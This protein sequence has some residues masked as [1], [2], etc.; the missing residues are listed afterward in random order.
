MRILRQSVYHGPNVYSMTPAVC[1][2][3]DASPFEHRAPAELGPTFIDVLSRVLPG[4]APAP[5]AGDRT[6][7]LGDPVLGWPLAIARAAIGLQRLIGFQVGLA[8][9][10]PMGRGEVAAIFDLGHPNLGETIAGAATRIVHDIA[11]APNDGAE[12]AA[13]IVRRMRDRHA[14]DAP[15]VMMRSLIAAIERRGIPWRYAHPQRRVLQLGH[16]CKMQRTTGNVAGRTSWIAGEIARDKALATRLLDDA[17]LP[18]TEQRLVGSVREGLAKAEELGFPVVVKPNFTGRGIAVAPMLQTAAQVEVALVAALEHGP[19]LVERHVEGDDHRLFVV[20]GR[21]VAVARKI[22]ASIVGDGVHSVRDLVDAVNRD[23]LRGATTAAALAEIVIDDEARRVL[24]GQGL[25]ETSVPAAGD[26]VLLRLNANLSTGGM[27]VDVTGKVHPDNIAMA[28][29]EARVIGLDIMGL[30]FLTPDI[31]RSHREV[32]GAICEVN[33]TPGVRLHAD[34]DLPTVVIDAIVD[35]MF[36]A[37]DDGR[38][39]IATITGSDGKTTTSHMVAAILQAAGHR[40]GLATTV[41]VRIDGVPVETGDRAGGTGAR[42]VLGDPSVTAAVLE[43]AH[44]GLFLRGLA[45]DRCDVGALMNVRGDHVGVD[46]I[47]SIEHLAWIKS[48]VLAVARRLAV[49]SADD[50]LCVR[51][52]GRA[53]STPICWVTT[54]PTHRGVLRHAAE[55][56]PAVILSGPPG[57]RRI[58]LLANGRSIPIVVPEAIPAAHGGKAFFN[59]ENAMFA[60]AIAWGLGVPPEAIGSTLLTYDPSR[61]GPPLRLERVREAPFPL[62]LDFAH[63][64]TEIAAISRFA[65]AQPVAGRRIIVI[66]SPGNRLEDHY[67]RIAAAAAGSF[68]LY[69]CS[70]N[71]S[72]ARNRPGSEIQRRLADGLRKAGVAAERIEIV[73]DERQAILRLLALATADDL[74]ILGCNDG[75]PVRATLRERSGGAASAAA[76]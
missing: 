23:P 14:S 20:D 2:V 36:P 29:R 61:H 69:L 41:G 53:G 68:D 39:P 67:D 25:A 12:A 51:Q 30:D 11:H 15:S 8:E 50:P 55:G 21:V 13:T 4:L 72:T 47:R 38:I 35:K 49:I 71:P 54:D 63:N 18:V 24:A 6:D 57:D 56:R 26:R 10:R 44:L 76:T 28:E 32:G 70:Q 52:R 3:I 7:G 34:G 37:G 40:V 9:A 27:A 46:R 64:P 45:F 62:Y 66:K 43:S 48:L 73:E 60:T 58:V 75:D 5:G 16:G 31:G 33:G 19:A 74:V 22:P 1:A 65:A 42:A 17:G 59:I